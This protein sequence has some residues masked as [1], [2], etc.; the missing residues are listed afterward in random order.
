MKV[1]VKR[2]GEHYLGDHCPTTY[3]TAGIIGILR[4]ARIQFG[5]NFRVDESLALYK[6]YDTQALRRFSEERRIR[7]YLTS[8]ILSGGTQEPALNSLYPPSVFDPNNYP[9][10]TIVQFTIMDH[11]FAPESTILREW[12]YRN[13]SK[14]YTD[15]RVVGGDY[16]TR[17]FKPMAVIVRSFDS[18]ENMLAVCHEKE[19]YIIRG[20]VPIRWQVGVSRLGEWVHR[21]VYGFKLPMVDETFYYE[22]F[23]QA[24]LVEVLEVGKKVPARVEVKNSS[25]S[26]APS[27]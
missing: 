22:S 18:K 14:Y 7:D 20:G 13:S 10:D 8:F 3:S 16:I 19:E 25:F 12:Q 17:I 26:V 5:H 23:V 6:R 11:T 15:Y 2:Y 24:T 27:F 4:A 21:G 9:L 1:E